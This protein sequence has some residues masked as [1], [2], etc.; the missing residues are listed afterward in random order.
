VIAGDLII[1][2]YSYGAMLDLIECYD[3]A[4]GSSNSYLEASTTWHLYDV[5]VAGHVFYA[6]AK[7]TETLTITCTDQPE[8]GLSIHVVS[9]AHDTLEEVLNTYDSNWTVDSTN[10]SSQSI[11]TDK[12]DCYLF[13]FWAQGDTSSTVAED[14]TGFTERTEESTHVHASF[15]RVVEVIG[16]YNND[17]TSSASQGFIN[18]ICAFNSIGWSSNSSSSSSSGSSSSSSA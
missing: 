16:T 3:N 17:I 14:G 6:I 2:G 11:T 18:I 8:S 4:S 1:V 10:H 15:D 9:G 7:A 13:C 5:D 12:D